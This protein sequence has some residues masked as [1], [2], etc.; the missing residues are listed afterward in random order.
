MR[1][2][3]AIFTAVT[4]LTILGANTEI[5]SSGAKV[6]AKAPGVSISEATPASQDRH[7]K[8]TYLSAK[9][10]SALKKPPASGIYLVNLRYVPDG[11]EDALA[12]LGMI[13]RAGKVK[14]TKGRDL[15]VLIGGSAI[16]IQTKK[17]EGENGSNP[18]FAAGTWRDF[19]HESLINQAHAT[20]TGPVRCVQ[21]FLIIGGL[22][23]SDGAL[24]STVSGHASTNVYSTVCEASRRAPTEADHIETGIR[25]ICSGGGRDTCSNC[26]STHVTYVNLPVCTRPMAA[27]FFGGSGS[28]EVNRSWYNVRI[29]DLEIEFE[30]MSQP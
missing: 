27:S 2:F 21:F 26:G 8:A 24:F 19:L 29:G 13:Y 14:D 9:K 20:D 5:A 7:I 25:F 10:L 11:V 12:K 6:K 18:A 1:I 28:P 3:S 30:G 4:M 15:I 16:N 22:R 17:S 23:S